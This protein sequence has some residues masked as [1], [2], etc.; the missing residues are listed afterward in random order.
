MLDT[1]FREEKAMCGI[2][3]NISGSAVLIFILLSNS[4]IDVQS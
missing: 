2:K 4:V 1:R 3:D